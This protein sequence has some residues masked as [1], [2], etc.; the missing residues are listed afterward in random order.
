MRKAIIRK[1]AVIIA[2]LM[3]AIFFVASFLAKRNRT[4]QPRGKIPNIR[5]KNP[6]VSTNASLVNMLTG[7]NEKVKN[8]SKNRIIPIPNNNL[9]VP[10]CSAIFPSIEWKCLVQSLLNRPQ[11]VKNPPHTTLELICST[12]SMS[13][14]SKCRSCGGERTTSRCWP[15]I[16]C[17]AFVSD[18]GRG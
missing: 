11:I 15:I 3:I 9:K 10:D 6:S 17:S 7:A 4:A 2:L 8:Q 1:A 13:S 16:F 5:R 12:V 14:A 18:W